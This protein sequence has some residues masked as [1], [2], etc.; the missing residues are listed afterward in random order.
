LASGILKYLNDCT[1]FSMESL[2]IGI[3]LIRNI[4]PNL[5][6]NLKSFHWS[7]FLLLCRVSYGW[8]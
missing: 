4:D 3:V 7:V 2:M 5:I 1:M 6:S 8:Y